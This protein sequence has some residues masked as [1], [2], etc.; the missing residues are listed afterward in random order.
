MQCQGKILPADEFKQCKVWTGNKRFNKCYSTRSWRFSRQNLCSSWMHPA[1]SVDCY[2]DEV[3]CSTITTSRKLITSF[4]YFLVSRVTNKNNYGQTLHL[5][6][7]LG[8]VCRSLRGQLQN[9][10]RSLC[11]FLHIFQSHVNC[12]PLHMTKSSL[13]LRTAQRTGCVELHDL[14]KYWCGLTRKLFGSVSNS[15]TMRA[16]CTQGKKRRGGN[17]YAGLS[18]RS[19]SHP[20]MHSGV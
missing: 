3:R 4:V 9:L 20:T 8:T 7:T 19:Q 17:S 10:F 2:N 14:W 6:Q 1:F 15:C 12:I 18:N 5:P 16:S 11:Y 13:S